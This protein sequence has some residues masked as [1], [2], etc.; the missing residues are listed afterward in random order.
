LVSQFDLVVTGDPFTAHIASTLRIP[1]FMACSTKDSGNYSTYTM[2]RC[3]RLDDPEL[4]LASVARSAIDRLLPLVEQ[5]KETKELRSELGRIDFGEPVVK[6]SG[7]VDDKH[8]DASLVHRE[9]R[10]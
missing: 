10:V 5:Q 1:T 4:D 9:Y 6:V 7:A 2:T 3:A 8:T